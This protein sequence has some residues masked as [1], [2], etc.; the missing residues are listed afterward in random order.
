MTKNLNLRSKTSSILLSAHV[1]VIALILFS[2]VV[3]SYQKDVQIRDAEGLE[4][5]REFI[6]SRIGDLF[7][8]A[9]NAAKLIDFM[10]RH[11]DMNQF[12]SVA[13]DILNETRFFKTLEIVEGEVITHIFPLKGNEKAM[14]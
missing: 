14:V 7:H 8:D 11:T 13:K 5:K 1:F 12:D 10:H 4:V 3:H 9:Y 6:E 2:L